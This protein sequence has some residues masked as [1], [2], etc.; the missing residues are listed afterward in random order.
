MHVYQVRAAI[1]FLKSSVALNKLDYF[2]KLLKENGPSLSSSRHLRELIPLVLQEEKYVRGH[3]KRDP[4]DQNMIINILWFF[5]TIEQRCIDMLQKHILQ[6][7]EKLKQSCMVQCYIRQK[8][9]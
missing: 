5:K 1:V 8:N 9:V 3:R 7:R 4:C 6:G 2:R